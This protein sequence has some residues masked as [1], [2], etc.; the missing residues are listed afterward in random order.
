M[1]AIGS[2]CS[3]L[4]NLALAEMGHIVTIDDATDPGD[5]FSRLQALEVWAADGVQ[6]PP[7]VIKQLLK[8]C[9]SIRNVFLRGCD[10]VDDALFAQLWKVSDSE[11]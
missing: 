10:A 4:R 11:T 5:F 6:L 8:S 3:Q 2:H 1:A 7:A 9:S